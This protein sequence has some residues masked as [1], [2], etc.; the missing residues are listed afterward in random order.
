[1][2]AYKDEMKKVAKQLEEGK[3][4]EPEKIEAKDAEPAGTAEP[5][6]EEPQEQALESEEPTESTELQEEP[7]SEEPLELPEGWSD[8]HRELYSKL[9][10][11]ARTLISERE[12][13]RNS[14]LQGKFREADE[15]K[16]KFERYQSLDRVLE[17]YRE[18]LHLNG[19]DEISFMQR[20]VAWNDFIERDPK[21]AIKRLSEAYK[22][23][24]NEPSF[25]DPQLKAL[26]DELAAL[27]QQLGQQESTTRETE[28]S[29]LR[30]EIESFRD[31]K[32]E[33]GNLKHPHFDKVR[34]AMSGLLNSEVATDLE[35]A[36]E[37]A[38]YAIPEL[39]DEL[40]QAKIKEARA[41]DEAERRKKAAEAKKAAV[42]VDGKDSPT[43]ATDEPARTGTGKIDWKTELGKTAESL[44]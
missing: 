14:S 39:R 33:T 27:K 20:L 17:P 26:N 42:A 12:K 32:D 24:L 6:T 9:P 37:K 29:A 36:Y 15:L 34:N 4:E 30:T 5:E 3:T 23:D 31:A 18:R 25:E 22:V 40:V 1:M 44:R 19:V 21:A 8:D 43:I 41:K 13:E 10:E 28:Q 7:A 11:E 2:G 35:D 38:V 16:K